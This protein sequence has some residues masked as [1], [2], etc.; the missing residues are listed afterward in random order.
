VSSE[1]VSVV[2]P[3]FAE[4]R[5]V[6]EIL[7][8]LARLLGPSLHEVRIV[9]SPRSPA[10]TVEIC[11]AA[12][13]ARAGVHV[14]VQRESPGVGY[15]FRQGIEEAQGDLI[16]LMDS[17]GEMD[18]EDVPRLLSTLRDRKADLVVGSR[19][20][21]GGGAEGYD[22]RKLLL[23]R[24][25]QALFRRLYRTPLHDLTFGFKLGRAQ[26]LKSFHYI[27]QFQEIGCEVTLRAVRAGYRVEEIPT[28]WRCRKEGVSTNPLKRNLRY[29]WTA[30]AVLIQELP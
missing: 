27:A 5:T 30:L 29:A 1:R 9:L 25:Y 22:G 24:V 11:Q 3:V 21:P 28:V 12:A 15:A 17:D 10:A 14:S 19:W 6:P 16:L 20:I 8:R 13:R 18:V 26:V 4:E 7:D 2:L 23:N